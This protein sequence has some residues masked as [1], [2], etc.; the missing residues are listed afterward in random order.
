GGELKVPDVSPDSIWAPSRRVGANYLTVGGDAERFIFYRGIGH[1]DA[2]IHIETVSEKDQMV[3]ITN[4]SPDSVPAA[5]LLQVDG[6]SGLFQA[7][8]TLPAQSSV[9]AKRADLAR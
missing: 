6:Q 9:R 3:E 4:S 7:V 1:F 2:P 8:G 5:F